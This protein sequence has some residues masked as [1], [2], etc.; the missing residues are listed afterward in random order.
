MS[1]TSIKIEVADAEIAT[2]LKGLIAASGDLLPVFEDIGAA[3]LFSSQRRFEA[4]AGPDGQPWAPFARST[5]KRMPVRR[6]PPQLLRD[7]GRLYSSLTFA[8][9]T[10]AVEIGTNLA[11]AAIHQF[12]GDI[13]IPERQGS[14]TF[15]IAAKGAGKAK[16]GRRVGSRLRFAR[17]NT[18]A[19]SKH[20]KEFT[21]PAYSISIPARPYLGISEGDKAE[22]LAII[23]D[24]LGQA[25]ATGAAP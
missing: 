10:G 11:Y 23:T 3:L 15:I 2:A 12:G 20:T 6:K 1:G 8:A 13:P 18:R 5:L 14:A 17:A 21:V 22:I 25:G 24:H 4:Q 16:D 9:D 19:K 7:R